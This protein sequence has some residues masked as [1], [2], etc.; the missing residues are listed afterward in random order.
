MPPEFVAIYNTDAVQIKS[1]RHF[2]L[3]SE[4]KWYF[5]HVDQGKLICSTSI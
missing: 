1:V 4:G 5:E 3:G 2:A